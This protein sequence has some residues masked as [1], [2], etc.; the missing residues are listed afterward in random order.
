MVFSGRIY[1]TNG[2]EAIGVHEADAVRPLTPV[3]QP[4]SLR[5]FRTDRQVQ[6]SDTSSVEDPS[7]FY[8]N[9]ACLVGASQLINHPEWTPELGFDPYIAAVL[10]ADG[11]KVDVDQADDMI[12]GFT[13]IN[14]LVARD[15]ERIEAQSG[16]GFGRSHDLGAAIGPVITT[17][18]EL[19]D[20]VVNH[21]DG[22]G[23]RL[24][25]VTRVNGVEVG[26]GNVEDLPFTFAQAISAASQ[27]CT[28]R[29]G[30][31]IALG[32]IVDASEEPVTL[33]PGDE[34]QI[35]VE[36]LGTLS[37]KLNQIL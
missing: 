24:S 1:E 33:R 3:P 20:M 13:M 28:L 27:S 16:I 17:P 12:L 2:A 19:D 31:V 35:S 37:L 25:T 18:D 21:G 36:V 8:G 4:G 6:V 7:F 29:A 15:V 23:F 9:P 11:Y 14:L 30:D 10:V 26:R 5:L 34:V 22:Q 32:P